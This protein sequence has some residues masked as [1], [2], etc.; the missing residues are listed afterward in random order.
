MTSGRPE[1][2]TTLTDVTSFACRQ[3]RHSLKPDDGVK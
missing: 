3:M 2:Y 1:N